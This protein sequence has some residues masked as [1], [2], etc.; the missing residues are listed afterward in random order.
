LWIVI[1][2]A[3]LRL[4]LGELAELLVQGQRVTPRR[5]LEAGFVFQHAALGGAIDALIRPG[6]S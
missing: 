6:R 5:L 1:P 3:A 4:A 2:G